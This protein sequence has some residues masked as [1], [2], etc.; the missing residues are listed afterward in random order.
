LVGAVGESLVG[1]PVSRIGDAVGMATD[2]THG[3]RLFLYT[4]KTCVPV[5]IVL[6]EFAVRALDEVPKI[7]HDSS[8]GTVRLS[9]K[10]QLAV[11]EEV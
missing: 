8:S 1:A 11:G 4:H 2:R 5:N 10:S 6:P 9:W 7:T 3:N